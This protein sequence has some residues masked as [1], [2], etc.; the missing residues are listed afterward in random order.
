MTLVI[1]D[2]TGLS[3]AESYASE[4]TAD[5]YFLARANA[6]WAALSSSAKEIALRQATQ[7]IDASNVDQWRGT[8][9][10][11]EQALDWPRWN[12]VV[13]GFVLDSDVLPRVLVEATCEYA[14]RFATSDTGELAVDVTDDGSITAESKQVGP[15]SVSTSYGGS[16]KSSVAWYRK[17]DILLARLR[18]GGDRLIRI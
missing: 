14:L 7:H 6:D 1:E 10:N 3:T 17:P 2:G 5:A 4:A 12:V 18:S 9:L 11:S 16:G 15:L 8:R 13:D